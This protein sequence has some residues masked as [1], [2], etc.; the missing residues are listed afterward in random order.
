[1]NCE[2]AKKKN[3]PVHLFKGHWDPFW[4]PH[5]V[6]GNDQPD[7]N[8]A[9]DMVVSDEHVIEFKNQRKS[10][11]NMESILVGGIPIYPSEKYESQ[12]GWWTPQYMANKKMFQST[13]QVRFRSFGHEKRTHQRDSE[14]GRNHKAYPLVMTPSLLLKPWRDVEMTTKVP[15][16]IA[17]WIV[18]RIQ[19]CQGGWYLLPVIIL[20]EIHTSPFVDDL[21]SK[22]SICP[23][24]VT[25][26]ANWK[27]CPP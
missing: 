27:L 21:I 3:P 25:N 24:V 13:N 6:A 20:V 7:Q 2:G 8:A 14:F 22:T 5:R 19:P 15:T 18:S 23:L 16:K 12:L 1:M 26:M 11:S 10:I 9:T 17:W 4:A